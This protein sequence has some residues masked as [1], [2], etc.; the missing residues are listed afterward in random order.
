MDPH[1]RLNQFNHRTPKSGPPNSR[2]M[3]APLPKPTLATFPGKQPRKSSATT[4]SSSSSSSSLLLVR[5]PIA[6]NSRVKQDEKYR[7][8][9]YLSF[10]TS[11]LQEKAKGRSE[12]FDDLVNQF[13]PKAAAQTSAQLR[14]WILTLSHV[15]SRLERV[16]YALI[17]AI[18]RMP[19]T[20][21]DIA[22]VKSYTI[23]IGMLLSA[24]PEYLSLVLGMIAQG[25]TYQSCAQAL[26]A[27]TVSGP[28]TRRTVYDRLH[29]LLKHILSL[30]P[31]LPSTLMPLLSRNFPH[32]RQNIASQSTYIRNLLRV[33]DYCPEL[34]DKILGTIIDRAIQI[35]VEIQVEL[36]EL[37]DAEAEQDQEVFELDPFDVLI[38]QEGDDSDTDS[39]DGDDFSDLSSDA[40]GDIDLDNN[41]QPE[42]TITNVRHIQN[43]VKKLD[44]ILT[45]TFEYFD[46]SQSSTPKPP[47]PSPPEPLPALD[48]P[49]LPPIPALHITFNT[50]LAIFDR[51]ILLTFKSRYTQFLLFWYTSLDPDFADIFLGMLIDRSLINPSTPTVTRAAA[52]SY[53][54]S[55]VSRARFVDREG[56]RTVLRVLCDFLA[57]HLDNIDHADGVE[58]A[59]NSVFYAVSQSLFLVFCFRWR[60]M[61]E[62]EDEDLAK[63]EGKK[64]MRELS[65]VHRVVN[66]PL[67]PLKVCSPNVAMQF[68]HVANTVGFMY[69]YTVLESNKRQNALA[70]TA[71]NR[72]FTTATVNAE[73][74]TFFPFDPYKLPRS[75][76]YIEGIYREWSEVAIDEDEDDEDEDEGGEVEDEM[77]DM[78]DEGGIPVVQKTE[79][80]EDP[81]TK[82]LGES[83]GA[84]S[85]SPMRP[86]IGI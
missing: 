75:G 66:S 80:E 32:K 21:L 16:H 31:T 58:S 46:R 18:V 3:E 26:D 1:S 45:L 39:E 68:A 71:P 17:E 61:Q 78:F 25:F 48:L 44:T 65:V 5:R 64:W 30:I 23:F 86:R 8:E 70:A 36:E 76:V 37:E 79:N 10:I 73:L 57:S 14:A 40:G 59:Q 34:S 13:N 42:A 47:S 54:G 52:A 33:C 24:R 28:V 6:T 49:P 50:L 20:I 74:N 27:S 19:W 60:D 84:M 62:E 11:A 9:M 2:F 35:D 38:G 85:I 12:R 43:M 69:C 29:Y 22:T 15:V 53:I 72:I 77:R 4:A 41:G 55:F 63:A 83:L 81:A 67:N 82:G 7:N 56:V 51:T